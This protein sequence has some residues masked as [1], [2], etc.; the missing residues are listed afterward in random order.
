MSNRAYNLKIK[1]TTTAD[2]SQ[3][4]KGTPKI[5][6]RGELMLRGQMRTRTVVAQGQAAELI[7]GM[8]RKG[9]NLELRC[10]FENAPGTEEGK[11]GGPGEQVPG[12][13][14]GDGHAGS[15]P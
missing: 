14:T 8:L 6:F 11:R 9:N 2:R 13:G 3:N 1:Q 5:K 7:S 10:L 15:S 4:V 12:G